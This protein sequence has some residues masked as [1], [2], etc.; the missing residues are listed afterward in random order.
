MQFIFTEEHIQRALQH[1]LDRIENAG[2]HAGGSGNLGEISVKITKIEPA[3]SVAPLRWRV[4]FEYT[5]FV[6]SEFTSYPDNPPHES[7]YRSAVLF[8]ETGE[9]AG[10]EPKEAVEGPN[11]DNSNFVDYPGDDKQSDHEK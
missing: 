11:L 10:E 3:E 4:A 8:D 1:R 5:V 6:V 2:E 7:H 9:I